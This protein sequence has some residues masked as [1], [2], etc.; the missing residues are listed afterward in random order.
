MMHSCQRQ[1]R[2]SHS[3]WAQNCD[4][5]GAFGEAFRYISQFRVAAMEYLWPGW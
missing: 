1:G 5:S 4:T 2:F 3:S